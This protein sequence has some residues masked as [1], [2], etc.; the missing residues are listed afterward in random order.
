MFKA[1]VN[2]GWQEGTGYFCLPITLNCAIIFNRNVKII[3]DV[4]FLVLYAES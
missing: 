1:Q 4:K 3:Q 2:K